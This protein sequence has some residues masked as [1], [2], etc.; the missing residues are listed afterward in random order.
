MQTNKNKYKPSPNVIPSSKFI[1]LTIT[2]NAIEITNNTIYLFDLFFRFSIKCFP[3]NMNF[4][5]FNIQQI[6]NVKETTKTEKSNEI[7]NDLQTILHSMYIINSNTLTIRHPN[8]VYIIASKNCISY[9]TIIKQ[10]KL[11]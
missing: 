10:S 9:L 8:N 3:N 1:I 5:F 7:S 2:P 4:A 11:M 6:P